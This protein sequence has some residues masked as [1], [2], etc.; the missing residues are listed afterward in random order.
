MQFNMRLFSS[1]L[2]GALFAV[3]LAI[4]G[5]TKPDNIIGFLDIFGGWRPELMFV[6]G[7]A[8][9]TLFIFKRL[10]LT[11]KKPVY[12]IKFRIPTRR[13]IN[14]ALIGGAAL[15]G[16]GWGLGGLCPGPAIVSLATFEPDIFIFLA[17]MAVGMTA[18]TKYERHLEK[19]Q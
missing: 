4:A 19:G 8:V 6:M 16:I 3:G 5:M 1:F 12:D 14:G 11:Q 7:A 15:F 18:H 13:D 2:S 17:A 10:T 9:T